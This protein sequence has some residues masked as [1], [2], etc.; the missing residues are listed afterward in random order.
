MLRDGQALVAAGVDADGQLLDS[1][2]LY[3]PATGHFTIGE[4]MFD[5]QS[6]VSTCVLADGRV[7]MLGTNEAGD[8]LRPEL[9]WP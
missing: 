5:P 2:E 1:T 4:S 7:L 6:A 8:P 3:D 9:Y